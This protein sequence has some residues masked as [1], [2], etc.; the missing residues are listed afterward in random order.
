MKIF[1]D[2]VRVPTDCVSYM[3][4]RIGSLNLIYLEEWFIVRNYEDFQEMV[5]TH[6]SKI[7]HIS[8]D[9]DL[10]EDVASQLRLEGKSKR[11]SRKIKKLS[12]SGY[13]CA[14]WLKRYYDRFGLKLPVM[15]VHSMNP[16][17]TE[18]IINVFK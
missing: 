6:T 14:V 16:V 2:D 11:A 17:G 18:R 8:F 4:A 3:H 5:I 12:K 15:F 1:L 9:H 10:G 13:D 7:T